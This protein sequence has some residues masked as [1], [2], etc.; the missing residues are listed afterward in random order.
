MLASKPTAGHVR[1]GV[2]NGQRIA[3]GWTYLS[4]GLAPRDVRIP[5]ILPAI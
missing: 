1:E 2:V 5:E 4:W 3:H